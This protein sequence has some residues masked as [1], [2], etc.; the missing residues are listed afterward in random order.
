MDKRI[1]WSEEDIE[2]LKQK[3]G[4]ITYLEMSSILNKPVSCIASK[5]AKLG[6]AKRPSKRWKDA[7][8]EF[9][10][11]NY[12]ILGAEACAKKLNKSLHSIWKK[13]S[14]IGLSHKNTVEIE[15][16]IFKLAD[17]NKNWRGYE[18]ISGSV[19]YGLKNNANKRN[20][21]FSLTIEYLWDLFVKQN[22]KCALSN[23]DISFNMTGHLNKK[24]QTASLDRIDSS[25]GYIEGNVQWVHKIVN[26][27]KWELKQE[28][29][30][31]WCK[32]I[33]ENN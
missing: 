13:V 9:L 30:I 27:I 29:F 4:I 32:I 25:K 12:H 2:F 5:I 31:H 8:L 6:I 11:K 23:V 15:P 16:I 21:E 18:E 28:D 26:Q 33:T 1:K 3:V 19:F 24:N 10:V 20:L 17:K 14:I 22:K 7:E